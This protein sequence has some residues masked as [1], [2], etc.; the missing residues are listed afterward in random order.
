MLCPQK[1]I[2]HP[3][4]DMYREQQMSYM[5]NYVPSGRGAWKS[6]QPDAEAGHIPYTPGS[7]QGSC[8]D[9]NEF[10]GPFKLSMPQ[11]KATDP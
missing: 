3:L 11:L 5:D 8:G 7:F 9:L 10:Q 4:A 6:R 1:A 2:H